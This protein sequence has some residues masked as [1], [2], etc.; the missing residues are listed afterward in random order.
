MVR[1]YQAVHKRKQIW[2]LC[3]MWGLVLSG[4]SS[5]AS[6]LDKAPDFMQPV[7][8]VV[9][10]GMALWILFADYAAKSAIA[11]SVAKQCETISTELTDLFANVYDPSNDIEEDRARS[12][13]ASLRGKL[14][15]ATYRSGDAKLGE[16][17]KINNK[18]SADAAKELRMSYA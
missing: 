7:A 3:T 10:A 18:A 17:K 15:E 6:L 11:H 5:A 12:A 14:T 13:L 8:G 1:Y 9:V 16:Y 2:N 4:T